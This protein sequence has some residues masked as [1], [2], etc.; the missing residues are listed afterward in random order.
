MTTIQFPT[1][2]V[3][4]VGTTVRLAL[5]DAN[6]RLPNEYSVRTAAP[7]A[8]TITTG[9]AVAPIGA[10]EITIVALDGAIPALAEV[11]IGG[12]TV[13]VRKNV[14][15]GDTT[16][17]CNPLTA[18]IAAA[19]T[20]TF[21]ATAIG[22]VNAVSSKLVAVE[23]TAVFLDA[24]EV[25]SFGAVKV[26]LTDS[27]PA[28]STLLFCV[29]LAAALTAAL[30]ATT[31]AL[32]TVVGA[33]NATPV[34]SPKTTDA[35]TYLSG[36]GVEMVTVGTNRTLN[37]SFN[38]VVGDMGGN[39]LMQILYENSLFDREVWAEVVRP[40][41]EKYE[42]ACL[43]TSGNQTAPVQEKITQ[44]A[45]MQFQG[46]SFIFTPAPQDDVVSILSLV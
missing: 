20:G 5:L 24:G 31:R 33:T 28:G 18:Q 37:L 3:T 14:K 44:E 21:T 39:V 25:L 36:T 12:Q 16:I 23:P 41:G 40:N 46:D 9:A 15:K 43:V 42:G 35:T 29:P 2:P 1:R 7:A 22:L 11:T 6:Y 8:V 34:S 45:N 38:R 19:A 26:I 30:S 10:R 32:L 4:T 27:A 17:L 13:V